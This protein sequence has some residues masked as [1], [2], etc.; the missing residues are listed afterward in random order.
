M[1]RHNYNHYVAQGQGQVDPRFD[2]GYGRFMATGRNQRQRDY[3]EAREKV[4]NRARFK[5]MKRDQRRLG[6]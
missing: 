4:E 6:E 2:L 5:K 1:S 3:D